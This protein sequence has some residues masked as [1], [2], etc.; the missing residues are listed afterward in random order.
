MC[1]R[2][3]RL[4]A[5][6]LAVVT[7]CCSMGAEKVNAMDS[8]SETAEIQEYVEKI[9]QE[10]PSELE[11]SVLENEEA[12]ERHKELL[13]DGW[14]LESIDVEEC[15]QSEGF[16]IST[17]STVSKNK[18][19]SGMVVCSRYVQPTKS[20][21]YYNSRTYTKAQNVKKYA[22]FASSLCSFKWSWVASVMFSIPSAHFAPY[23]NNGYQ[24]TEE[25]GTLYVK[26][27]YYKEGKKYYIGYSVSKI[28]TSVSIMSYY[29]DNKK[30]PHQSTRSYNRSYQSRKYSY[31]DSS[32]VDLARRHYDSHWIDDPIVYPKTCKLN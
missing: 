25:N 27:A 30:I 4:Q 8:V 19:K 24:K 2:K 14:V 20:K 21:T 18:T 15:S 26:D 3:K 9:K 22:S 1:K 28:Y 6:L 12:V 7:I 11:K 23:F 29:R 10:L 32:L 31:S 5:L 17:F 16:G 13:E